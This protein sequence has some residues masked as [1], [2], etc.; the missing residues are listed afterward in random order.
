MK[1]TQSGSSS[2]SA[3]RGAVEIREEQSKRTQLGAA[4]VADGN[5]EQQF[6]ADRR[7]RVA[8]AEA[9]A[10]LHRELSGAGLLT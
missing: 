6:K 9:G 3:I 5:G 1:Q 2:R 10:A 4:A 7:N 8:A